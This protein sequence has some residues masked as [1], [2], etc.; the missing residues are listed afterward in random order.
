MPFFTDKAVRRVKVLRGTR[1]SLHTLHACYDAVICWRQDVTGNET[2]LFENQ[3]TVK[4]FP[5][6]RHRSS[7]F[8][9]RKGL[10][11]DSDT[12]SRAFEAIRG[13]V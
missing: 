8:N 1:Q 13:L 2:R 12:L 3:N 4:S 6:E 7:A 11:R 9:N 5:C 10:Q